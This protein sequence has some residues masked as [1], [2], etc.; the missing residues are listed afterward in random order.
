M[1]YDHD[2]QTIFSDKLMRNVPSPDDD[3][4]ETGVLDSM[5]FIDLV[6]NLEERFGFTLNIVNLDIEQF[7]SIRSIADMVSSLHED[8]VTGRH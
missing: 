4:L 1:T 5:N 7:R 3:L 2:V 6:L 8:D